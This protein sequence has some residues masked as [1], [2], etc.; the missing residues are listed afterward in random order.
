MLLRETCDVAK[1][2]ESSLTPPTLRSRLR[3]AQ[4]LIFSLLLLD[5]RVRQKRGS[6]SWFAFSI[7]RTSCDLVGQD[8]PPSVTDVDFS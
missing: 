7:N 1:L 8:G 5:S 4:S 3:L 6:G 2:A